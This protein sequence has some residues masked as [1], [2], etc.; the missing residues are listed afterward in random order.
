MSERKLQT[1]TG[2]EEPLLPTSTPEDPELKAKQ[3]QRMLL[4]SF[5]ALV[6]V[7]LGNKIFQKLQ[8]Y[9]MYNYPY[10]LSLYVTFIYVP[11]SFAYIIPVIIWGSAITKEQRAIPWYKFGVMGALDGI[12]GKSLDYNSSPL[13]IERIVR[14]YD[15]PEVHFP[16]FI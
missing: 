8:T 15:Q 6:V 10:F 4:L 14:D 1:V 7:G 9:P 16:L 5:L 3:K 12:A 2:E 13:F 11:L